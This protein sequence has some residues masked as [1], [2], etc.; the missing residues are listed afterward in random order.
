MKE[1]L[2]Y[3]RQESSTFEGKVVLDLLLLVIEAYLKSMSPLL[4]HSLQTFHKLV[5]H[6]TVAHAQE[7]EEGRAHTGA[8]NVAHSGKSIKPIS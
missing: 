4:Q 8:D 3:A 2:E 5:Q 6:P 7:N 1:S